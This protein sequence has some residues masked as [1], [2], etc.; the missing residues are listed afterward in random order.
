MIR[1]YVNMA[2]PDHWF[3][4]AFMLPGILI[5]WVA[6][7]PEQPLST[8]GWIGLGVIAAC[9]A[10]SSNYTINEW[11]DAPEDKLHPE[12]KSRPAAAGRV[13][14]RIVYFEWAFLAASALT[15]AWFVGLM[16]LLSLLMLLVMGL[17]YNVRPVRL[18]D[19]PYLDVLSEGVNNPLRLLLGWYA[20][21]SQL[22]PPASLLLAYW[23][24][25]AFLMAIKRLAEMRHLGDRAVAMA[26][27]QSFRHYTAE[28]LLVSIVFYASAFAFFAGVFL[29]RYRVELILGVPFLAGFMAMYLRVGFLPDSPARRPE[30]LYKDRNLMIYIVLAV[31]ALVVCMWIRMPWLNAL[32]QPTI[33]AG[34]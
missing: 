29:I 3:K 25:G 34:L 1:D 2:R 13:K 16:F 14:A 5:A 28:R 19:I 15:L 17:L 27:R 32:F 11:L 9:L 33:P 20:V 26:Y 23:M 21:G 22:V 10:C 31:L 18:K 4:N 8:L 7:P 6:S 30:H 12:K 24:L